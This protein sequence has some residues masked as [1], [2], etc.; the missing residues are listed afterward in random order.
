MNKAPSFGQEP[1]LHTTQPS[2]VR[3]SWIP[4][5][6]ARTGTRSSKDLEDVASETLETSSSTTIPGDLREQRMVVAIDYGTTFTG[7][8]W[9]TL[10]RD[11]VL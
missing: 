8:R 3:E 5:R 4:Y 6:K 11:S 2:I 9:G 1:Y 10:G 7:K